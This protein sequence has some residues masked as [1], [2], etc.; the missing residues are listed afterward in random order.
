MTETATAGSTASGVLTPHPGDSALLHQK[1]AFLEA[2]ACVLTSKRLFT[3][4][5]EGRHPA[6]DELEDIPLLPEL[7]PEHKDFNA[8]LQ[9]NLK[10]AADNRAK[11]LKRYELFAAA[12]T[13]VYNLLADACDKHA[14]M[15]YEYLKGACDMSKYEP[16]VC[17]VW[18]GRRAWLLVK[19]DAHSMRTDEDIE[20]YN[21][22]KEVQ[23]KNHLPDGCSAQDFVDKATAFVTNI[24]PFLAQPYEPV[25]QGKYIINLM[26]KALAADRNRLLDTLSDADLRRSNDVI[27]K[28]RDV[29]EHRIGSSGYRAVRTKVLAFCNFLRAPLCAA[30]WLRIGR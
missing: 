16:P 2:A 22:A 15:L 6:A 3:L 18:D 20:F 1:R 11:A 29:F 24:N 10:T 21:T 28:C 7:P 8:R 4:A 17:G 27:A 19:Q 9:F 14:P 26:P 25:D 5:E 23:L 12:T 30:R 13:V